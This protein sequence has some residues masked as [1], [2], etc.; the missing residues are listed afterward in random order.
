[1]DLTKIKSFFEDNA[2]GY[3]M[4]RL[5]FFLWILVLGFNITYTTICSKELKPLDASYVTLTLG[6]AVSKAAQRLGENNPK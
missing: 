3:S 2:D 1:M 6:L 4:M 5:V